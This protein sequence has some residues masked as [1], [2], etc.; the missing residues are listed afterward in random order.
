MKRNANVSWF[1]LALAL[2]ALPACGGGAA[3]TPGIDAAAL[4]TQ[5]AGTES[6]LQTL[7]VQLTPTATIALPA[8]PTPQ[9]TD[10]AL[11]SDTP[12]PT[13]TPTRTP[14]AVLPVATS[15]GPVPSMH[16]TL[17]ANDSALNSVTVP[18]D[19]VLI[20]RAN[21]QNTSDIPM[22]VVANLS[23]PDGWGVSEDPYSDCPKTEDLGLNE[24][25]TITWKFNPM[26]SGQVILRVYVRGIYTDADGNSQRITDSPAFIFNVE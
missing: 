11:P 9:A 12:E 13:N 10:T 15:A 18:T 23:V 22:Q 21:V 26:V 6:A 16:V 14:Q 2:L 3:V 1:F 19:A 17:I 4:F 5:V 24:D 7:I 20:F 25:C 8:S